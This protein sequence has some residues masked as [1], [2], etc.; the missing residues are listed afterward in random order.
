MRRKRITAMFGV[1]ACAV[2]LGVVIAAPGTASGE[3]G[4]L[5]FVCSGAGTLD[6]QDGAT[7]VWTVDG[8]GSCFDIALPAGEP[9]TIQFHG[10]G[11]SDPFTCTPGLNPS[12]ITTNLNLFVDV[13]YTGVTTGNVVVQNQH[14]FGPI[15]LNRL[16]TP[17]LVVEPGIG[18]SITFHRIF[19]ACGND[20]GHPK[21]NY[22][23]ATVGDSPS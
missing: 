11:T 9:R 23:W 2:T 16:A 6:I 1:L 22:E 7:P 20:D 10:T 21:A 19:L 18:A 5:S 17:T 14:W 4:H 3:A 8:S 15:T 13:T 12:L